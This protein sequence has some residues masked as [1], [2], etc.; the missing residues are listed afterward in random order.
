MFPSCLN[1]PLRGSQCSHSRPAHIHP[2]SHAHAHAR[3]RA[4]RLRKGPRLL[5]IEGVLHAEDGILQR[6]ERLQTRG[7]L[8]CGE[9]ALGVHGGDGGATLGFD[10]G[11]WEPGWP[12]A[13][14]EEVGWARDGDGHFSFLSFGDLAK[15]KN[16]EANAACHDL[17]RVY[18]QNGMDGMGIEERKQ[19]LI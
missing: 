1:P 6:E 3:R 12:D 14:R 15:R 5:E 9:L 17:R 13:G 11:A 7:E 19:A 10:H 4:L 8:E 2:S 16:L 18:R